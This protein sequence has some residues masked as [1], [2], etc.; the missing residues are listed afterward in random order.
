MVQ[1]NI[2]SINIQT[3]AGKASPIDPCFGGGGGEMK[4]GVEGGLCILNKIKLFACM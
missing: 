4:G 1:K 2:T 3:Q